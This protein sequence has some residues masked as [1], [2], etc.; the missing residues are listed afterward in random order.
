MVEA[1]TV[2]GNYREFLNGVAGFRPSTVSVLLVEIS[3]IS[4][5]DYESRSTRNRHLFSTKD[6]CPNRS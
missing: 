2:L 1:M 4:L 5:V 3:C 6:R